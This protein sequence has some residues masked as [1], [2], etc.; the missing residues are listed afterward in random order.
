[1]EEPIEVLL[2]ETPADWP[3]AFSTYYPEDW[4]VETASS[5][6]GDGVTF[7]ANY[8]G[9]R[10]DQVT[11]TIFAYPAGTDADGAQELAR[12]LATS[13]GLAELAPGERTYPWALTEYAGTASLGEVELV[14]RLGLGRHGDRYFSILYQYPPEFGDGFAPRAAVVLDEWRWSDTGEPLDSGS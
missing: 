1:M 13:L 3:L 4:L 8:G 10:N 11:L 2:F 12:S 9:T 14:A 5:G 7:V 6:E